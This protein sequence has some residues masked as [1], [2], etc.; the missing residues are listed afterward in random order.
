MTWTLGVF[1]VKMK[2]AFVP[3]KRD[4]SVN[5]YSRFS[6]APRGSKRSEWVS[7]WTEQESE[8]NVAKRTEW[9]EWAVQAN[10]QIKRPSGPFKTR[11][12][13]TRNAPLVMSRNEEGKKSINNEVTS[14]FFT[15]LHSLSWLLYFQL[16]STSLAQF[17]HP[18]FILHMSLIKWLKRL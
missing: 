17:A 14:L 5:T 2:N 6:T 1:P 11:S 3:V 12:S 4:N 8:A 15:Y 13:L 7:L 9:A 16:Y 10:E 18:V